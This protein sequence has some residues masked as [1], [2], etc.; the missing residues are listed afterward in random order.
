ML[1]FTLSQGLRIAK[2]CTAT[3]VCCFAEV[4]E[5]RVAMNEDA[6]GGTLEYVMSK[7]SLPL[8]HFSCIVSIAQKKKMVRAK[9]SEP[10]T[11]A[12][13]SAVHARA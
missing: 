10:E 12:F 4:T 1:D 6:E 3:C 8:R 11:P 9:V 7:S 5:K 13:F 2:I